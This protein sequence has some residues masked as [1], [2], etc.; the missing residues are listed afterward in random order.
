LRNA[1]AG[2]VEVALKRKRRLRRLRGLAERSKNVYQLF[3]ICLPPR[4]GKAWGIR[5]E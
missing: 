2:G 5:A 1:V 4:A 3:L